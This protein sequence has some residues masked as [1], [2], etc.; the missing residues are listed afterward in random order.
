M[1]ERALL[2][3]AV[4]LPPDERADVA[5][6]FRIVNYSPARTSQGAESMYLQSRSVAVMDAK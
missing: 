2:R 1:R 6:E 5:A 3:E 4:T